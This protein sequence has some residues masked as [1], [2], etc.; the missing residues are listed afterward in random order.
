MI[1]ARD[2]RHA[3]SLIKRGFLHEAR[4]FFANL[5]FATNDPV[6]ERIAENRLDELD[7]KIRAAQ[8]YMSME[9]ESITEQDD[10]LICCVKIMF[11]Q[12][13]FEQLCIDLYRNSHKKDYPD[14]S[15]ISF[16]RTASQQYQMELSGYGSDSRCNWCA[17]FRKN[18]M[19][20]VGTGNMIRSGHC[21]YG[22][23]E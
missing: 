23:E 9:I 18:I 12:E 21:P 17:L 13:H 19:Y 15:N 11:R 4:A 7:K 3:D 10:F 14:T 20:Y 16:T 1:S 6:Q 8:Q 5:L 2:I 22:F